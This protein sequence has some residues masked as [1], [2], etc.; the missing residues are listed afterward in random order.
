MFLFKT[1]GR[2][3]GSVVAN[4]KH[5]FANKPRE[6]DHGEWV[7]VSKNRAD[8]RP[9]E[10]QIQYL[11]RL[12]SIR[13]L[14]PGESNRYWPGTEGRWEYLVSC[15]DTRRLRRPFNLSEALGLGARDFDGVMTFKRLSPG[16]ERRVIA[17]LNDREPG[18]LE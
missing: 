14:Q 4:Q 17:F 5:A 3:I 15:F 1:S 8:C 12:E 13:P 7:L 2:T 18:T 16:D 6:W 9:G 11:M 10:R